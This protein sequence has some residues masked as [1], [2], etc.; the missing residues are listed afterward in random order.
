MTALKTITAPSGA[1]FTVSAEHA[2]RFQ[3]LVNDLE[4]AG[5]PIKSDQSGGYNPRNI[6]GTNK[7]SLHSYGRAIDVNWNENAR[8]KP[9]S[10]PEAVALELAKKHGMTWGGQWKN[11]DDMHFEVADGAPVPMQNRGLTSFAGLSAPKTAPMPT[12]ETPVDP[13]S[14]LMALFQQGGGAALGAGTPPPGGAPAG[15]GGMQLPFG[16]GGAPKSQA[17]DL[18]D[19]MAGAGQMQTP[20]LLGGQRS[21]MDMQALM[22]L[23]ATKRRGGIG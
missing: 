22:Q 7:P 18:P 15:G 23:A 1:R 21:P 8:G 12:T 17:N 16:L 14:M 2:D 4:A 11:R 3:A 13:V 5:Y 6:A 19:P 9:G 20:N 10:I